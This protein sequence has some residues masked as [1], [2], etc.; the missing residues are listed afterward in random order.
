MIFVAIPLE[1]VSFVFELVSFSIYRAG[2][3]FHFSSWSPFAYLI[4]LATRD[5]F[6]AMGTLSIYNSLYPAGP[7]SAN[8]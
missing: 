8:M 3:L 5:I 2:L 1:L 7:P 6:F 4:S